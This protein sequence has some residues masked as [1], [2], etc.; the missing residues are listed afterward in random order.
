MLRH[1]CRSEQHRRVL[2]CLLECRS[3]GTTSN[4]LVVPSTAKV[5]NILYPFKI[6]GKVYSIKFLCFRILL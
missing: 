1:H 5:S 6:V 3:K 4:P 2:A